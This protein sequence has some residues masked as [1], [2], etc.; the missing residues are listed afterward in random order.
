MFGR[1]F[2]AT[3]SDK[4]GRKNTYLAFGILGAPLCLAIPQLTHMVTVDPTD[5][6]LWAFVGGS[7]LLISC[8]GGLLGV[9]P[10]YIADT[11]GLKN[12]TPIFGRLMTGCP[13][14]ISY[15]LSLLIRS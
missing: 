8:Y 11:F 9:L 10:A 4:I 3:L 13:Y 12:T 7:S 14:F 5:V 1:L 15:F 2:W 6:P